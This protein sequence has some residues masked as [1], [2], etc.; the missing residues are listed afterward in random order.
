MQVFELKFWLFCS[1]LRWSLVWKENYC[2]IPCLSQSCTELNMTS[3]YI[4]DMVKN[5]SIF[6]NGSYTIDRTSY[7][8]ELYSVKVFSS[9]FEENLV[10]FL[11]D[12]EN[13]MTIEKTIYYEIF[14]LGNDFFTETYE[15]FKISDNNLWSNPYLNNFLIQFDKLRW[16]DILSWKK[17]KRI[18]NL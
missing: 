7:R 11:K 2:F 14:V 18:G 15:R 6:Y 13:I 4:F 8:H 9:R 3:P 10:M 17:Y 16:E 5:E 1:V 12:L